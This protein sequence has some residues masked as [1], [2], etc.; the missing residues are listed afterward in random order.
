LGRVEHAQFKQLSR[1]VPLVQGVTHVQAL[2]ALQANEIGAERGRHRTGERGLADA[3]LALE[4][5]RALQAKREKQGD[6]EAAV[7]DVV[8]RGEALLKFGD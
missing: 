5:Q 7:R 4:K 1:V 3:G 6:R 8:G 2:V